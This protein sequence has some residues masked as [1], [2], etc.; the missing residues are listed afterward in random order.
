VTYVDYTKTVGKWKVD[1]GFTLNLNTVAKTSS[2]SDN[3]AGAMLGVSRSTFKVSYKLNDTVTLSAKTDPTGDD[4]YGNGSS[5]YVFN[6]AAQ[7]TFGG[8]GFGLEVPLGQYQGNLGAPFVMSI[9]PTIT[10]KISAIEILARPYIQL[11]WTDY[12]GQDAD[13]WNKYK[14]PEVGDAFYKVRVQGAYT[15]SRFYARLRFEIPTGSED[16]K[17]NFAWVGLTV[18]PYGEFTIKDTLK[19]TLDLKFEKIGADEAKGGKVSFK[20]TIGVKYTI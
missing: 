13:G 17:G 20:P 5:G 12:N 11:G 19:A 6:P 9:I 14:T 4:G 8:F 1:A 3:T 16:A 2:D 18:Q 10:Y 15:A 7:L